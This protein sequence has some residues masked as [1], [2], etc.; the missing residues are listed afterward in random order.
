VTLLRKLLFLS[1]IGSSLAAPASGADPAVKLSADIGPRPVAEALAAFGRQMGLQLIY[2]SRIA[3]AQ[4]SKGAPAGLTAS[5]ALA[6]LLDGTGLTFEFL[7]ARTVRIFPAPTIVPTTIAGS[8]LPQESERRAPLRTVT[9]EE[10]IV[11]ATRREELASRVPISMAVWTPE[12]MEASGVKGMAAIAALTPAVEYDYF[13][14]F[15]AGIQSN[16]AMRGVTS[17]NGTTTGIYLN[18]TPL[19]APGNWG[20]AFGP[21]FPATFD[22]QRVEV[23][24]GPQSTLLGQNAMGGAVRFITNQPSL[25]TFDVLVHSEIATTEHGDPSYEIGAAAGGPLINSRVGF[26]LATWYRLDSGFVD[27]VPNPVDQPAPTDRNANWSLTK[28]ARGAITFAPSPTV[29]ITPS[30]TYQSTGVHDSS[31]LNL[32]LSNLNAGVFI[33]TKQL[34]EPAD[35]RFYLASLRLSATLRDTEI[36]AVSSYFHRNG[37]AIID[38]TSYNYGGWGYEGFPEYVLQDNVPGAL[39][40]SQAVLSQELRLASSH[41]DA[42]FTWV[43]GVFYSHARD[44][45]TDRIGTPPDLGLLHPYGYNAVREGETQLG[46]FGNAT[47]RFTKRLAASAGV[48]I[49]RA[50][51]YS[52][53]YAG[54]SSTRGANG[55]Y[56]FLPPSVRLAH[57]EAV[58]APS[59]AFSFQAKP[60][61]LF[62]ATVA[63]G[64]RPGG[65]NWPLGNCDPTLRKT[66]GPDSLWSHEI[67]TKDISDSGRVQ[68]STSLFYV[69]WKKQQQLNDAEVNCRYIGNLA[70]AASRGMDVDLQVLV[71]HR[72]RTRLAAAYTDSHFTETLVFPPGGTVPVT[73]KGDPIGVLPAVQSPWNLN[74][75]LDYV[76]PLTTDI[77]VSA[78]VED[79]LHSRIAAPQARGT[80][81][82]RPMSST[83]V[84]D[85]LAKLGSAHFELTVRIDNTLGA[86]PEELLRSQKTLLGIRHYGTTLRPRTLALVGSWRP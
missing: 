31:A 11:T 38:A 30:L 56:G 21:A 32:S 26:R 27:R 57:H 23:L 72:L 49:E 54:G 55:T 40:M 15:G 33:N 47:L 16:I 48:R 67:G 19:P 50:E 24:R 25:D 9:L 4:Q 29:R 8:P 62:Y 60:T 85:C 75:S 80:F 20:S 77:A 12:T 84:L 3:E 46:G 59:F 5:E 83:N 13:P 18:D 82:E 58:V 68:F 53:E 42:A 22:L 51:Y 73:L 71:T 66:E 35:D 70:D 63:K 1:L 65:A 76:I 78:H 52:T 36:T 69:S 44:H 28:T 10:V 37:T 81:Y 43:A 41:P 7:N 79:V 86:H 39:D 74:A 14:D 64:Y 2:V 61:Q 17:R 6:Q 34:R 45:E